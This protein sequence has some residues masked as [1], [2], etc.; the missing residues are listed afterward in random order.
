VS[1][2]TVPAEAPQSPATAT[3]APGA[4]GEVTQDQ[5]EALAREVR[6]LGQQQ[7]MTVAERFQLLESYAATVAVLQRMEVAAL[8]NALTEVVMLNGLEST[9]LNQDVD[10]QAEAARFE[11]TYLYSRLLME[12]QYLTG[13]AKASRLIVPSA[14]NSPRPL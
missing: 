2:P 9:M 4:G 7:G 1:E 5:I 8:Q 3:E 6:R 11:K 13:K 12:Y 10:L 14:A